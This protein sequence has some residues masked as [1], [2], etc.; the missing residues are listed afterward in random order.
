MSSFPNLNRKCRPP[1]TF[2][3]EVFFAGAFHLFISRNFVFY[4][5]LRARNRRD[6]TRRFAN[7]DIGV[8]A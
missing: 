5:L 6:Q 3:A 1:Y 8:V 7:A 2:L 4:Y